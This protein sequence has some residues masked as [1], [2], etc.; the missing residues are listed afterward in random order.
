MIISLPTDLPTGVL[1]LPRR[2]PSQNLL[3]Y[4]HWSRYRVERDAWFVLLRSRLPPR[5]AVQVPVGL[6][7]RS[8]RN[9][10]M[11]YANLVG[12]AK[13]IPDCLIRLGY[14]K[15]DGPRWFSCDYQQIQVP[16]TEERT[17]LEF[18]PWR[19]C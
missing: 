17:E 4:R 15:D 7:L 19:E 14:L 10:L 8:Y 3:H 1:V 9:R 16:R 11:D 5:Q 13:P 18:V 2:I 6:V 12:G